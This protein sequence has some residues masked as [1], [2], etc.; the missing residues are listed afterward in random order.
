M[1]RSASRKDEERTIDVF[2]GHCNVQ[3][4]A[5]VMATHV[6]STPEYP[7]ADPCDTPHEVLEYAIAACHRCESVFLVELRFC[8]VPGEFSAPQGERVLYPPVRQFPVDGMPATVA[9]TY[10]TAA[11]SFVRALYEPCVIMC[12][13]CLEA[14]CRE[15]GAFG[16]TLKEQLGKLGEAGQIDQ[17]LL[18]WANELRLIGNDAAHDLDVVI[19]QADAQD[20]LDFVEAI[21]MYSFSLNRRFEEFQKRRQAARK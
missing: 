12:R 11:D 7:L 1:R 18:V 21:L 5:C 16:G 2:C 13:K 6:K 15:L 17:K 20:A 14:F 3:V 4:R 8:E 9:R 10:S 19:K